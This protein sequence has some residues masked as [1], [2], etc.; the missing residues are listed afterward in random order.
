MFVDF[1]LFGYLREGLCYAKGEGLI[2]E[3]RVGAGFLPC[4]GELGGDVELGILL[5]PE[6][7]EVR[8]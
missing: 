3:V 4:W 1:C 7:F 2:G 6:G 8:S 5:C